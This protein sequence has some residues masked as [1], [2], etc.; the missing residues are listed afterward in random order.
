MATKIEKQIPISE[1]RANMAKYFKNAEKSPVIVSLE[2]GRSTRVILSS[3]FYNELMEA[4]EDKQDTENLI[5]LQKENNG[6]ST[7]SWRKLRADL[8]KKHGI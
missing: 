5:K 7:V 8:V 1:V 2:R 4:Y 3:K 6:K